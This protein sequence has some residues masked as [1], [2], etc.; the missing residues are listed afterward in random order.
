MLD[1]VTG[2][3]RAKHSFLKAILLSEVSNIF[4]Y[5]CGPAEELRVGEGEEVCAAILLML[6]IL[7][8]TNKQTN[9]QT[10]QRNQEKDIPA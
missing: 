7:N 2:C 4:N 10:E 3:S 6:S 5:G 1:W 8:Q 9:K